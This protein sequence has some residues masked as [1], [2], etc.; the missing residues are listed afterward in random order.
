MSILLAEAAALVEGSYAV[1]SQTYG[2]QARGGDTRADVIISGSPIYYPKVRQP[3]ILVALTDEAASKYLPQIRPGGLCLYDSDLVHPGVRV[4]ARRKGLPMRRAVVEALGSATAFNI[5]VL[6]ALA[7]LSGAVSVQ[8][9]EQLLEKR[10]AA[11]LHQ[12]NKTALHLGA[13][14]A[15]PLAE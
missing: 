12:A 11:P 14:L 3:N 7:V 9:L 2:P 6:G 5:C 10:F 8:A 13:E 15:A 4:D 1:Q